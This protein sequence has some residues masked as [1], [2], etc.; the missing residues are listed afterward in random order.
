MKRDVL[1]V[2]DEQDNLVVFQATFEDDFNIVTA[3]SGKEAL[4]LLE[5]QSF[6]VIVA[7]QRMP[8]MTGTEFFEQVRARYPLTRRIMLTGYADSQAMLD[9]INKGQVYYFIKKPWDHDLVFSTIVRAL[10]S[11][12]LA[13]ANMALTDRLVANDRCATLG[14]S[15]ARIAHEIGNQLCML[16][17]LELIEE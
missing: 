5:R 2:D 3:S 12:D 8:G 10:E 9:A 14:R 15:A 17:L 11:Y 13:M 6:P 16:P 4:E 1:Y 7:D